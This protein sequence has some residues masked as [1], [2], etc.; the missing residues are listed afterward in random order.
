VLV[1]SEGS[2][3]GGTGPYHSPGSPSCSRPRLGDGS[4]PLS[5]LP[6]L[7]PSPSSERSA[8]PE[9]TRGE[10]RSARPRALRGK[11]SGGDGSVPLHNPLDLSQSSN[12]RN[13]HEPPS[14]HPCGVSYPHKTGPV[15]PGCMLP[16]TRRL[17]G[18]SLHSSAVGQ[19]RQERPEVKAC[20]QLCAENR[21]RVRRPPISAHNL[22]LFPQSP[23]FADL[24]RGLTGNLP[25][26]RI[27]DAHQLRQRQLAHPCP[28]V[29]GPAWTE[30]DPAS[31]RVV[32]PV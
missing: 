28:E 10:S 32:P 21:H 22:G 19:I 17:C 25:G 4:V 12:R 30:D 29:G 6:L 3:V 26:A 24:C 27:L 1:P 7:L 14:I 11:R 13:H 5:R 15:Q 20:S 8:C 23:R 31:P 9:G 18:N 2:G 16:V